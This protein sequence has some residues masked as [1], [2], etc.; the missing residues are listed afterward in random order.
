MA[1]GVVVALL[2]GVAAADAVAARLKTDATLHARPSASSEAVGQVP[3]G[4]R[5]EVLSESGGWHEVNSPVG[6]GFVRNDQLVLGESGEK[7]TKVAEKK[8]DEK[9]PDDKAKAT[10]EKKPEESKPDEKKAEEKK[11]AEKPAAGETIRVPAEE[12]R[13]LTDEVRLLRERPEPATAADLQRVEQTL[14]QAITAVG[15]K[16]AAPAAPVVPADT[17]LPDT[18]LESVLAVSPV[19]LILGGIIGWVAGRVTQRRRDNRNRIRV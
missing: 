2:I 17:Q 14:T 18:S 12:W 10:E 16:A 5:V 19:L 8:P 6:R 4:T 13:Q 1:R 7:S 9:K 15:E 11:P 3:A